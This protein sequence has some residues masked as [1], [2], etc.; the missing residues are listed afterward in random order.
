MHDYRIYYVGTEQEVAHHAAP[1]AERISV[2][3]IEPERVAEI[4]RPGDLAIFFSEHFHRFRNAWYQLHSK[5]CLTLYAIDGILEWR[6][7]WENSSEE[8]ACPWTMRPVLSNKVACIGNSQGAILDSWGNVGKTEIVGLPRL[9]AGIVAALN[10]IGRRDGTDTFHVLVTTAKWPGYTTEQRNTIRQSLVDLHSFSLANQRVQDRLLQWTWRLTAGLANEIGV[11]NSLTETTGRELSGLLPDVDAVIT[12]P[13]TVMLESMLNRIPT[14]LLDYTNS[15]EYVSAPW[16][17]N[18]RHQIADVVSQLAWPAASRML[19]QKTLLAEALQ[20]EV[21]ASERMAQLCQSMIQIAH[22]CRAR[23]TAVAFP[24]RILPP[25]QQAAGFDANAI[26]PKEIGVI[27]QAGSAEFYALVRENQRVLA[28]LQRR[29]ELLESELSRAAEGF[30]KIAS[31]P[32]LAPLLKLR[33][34]AMR[35]GNQ[36]GQV[37][38]RDERSKGNESAIK[39]AEGDAS[40]SDRM[41]DSRAHIKDNK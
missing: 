21:P 16:R 27:P 3:V 14:A 33:Q 9:D 2:I 30:E 41:F 1:L 29:I 34:T 40:I 7:A 5:G 36:I 32:I 24:G 37:L 12:T 28:V 11:E 20:F 23:G 13:S 31:H 15:P 25:I 6:N 35:F 38:S 18:A 26:W 22:D 39:T 10:A 17:I 19:Y 4:A 8:P